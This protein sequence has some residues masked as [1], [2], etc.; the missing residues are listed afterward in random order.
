MGPW[1]HGQ[2]IGDGSSLGEI[3]FD[4]DTGLYFRRRILLPF[5][6]HFLK[7]SGPA[8]TTAPV[9]AFETGANEW[10]RLDAWPPK[11]VI[12]KP[13]YLNAG[14][15]VSFD[16][17]QAGSAAWEE[18]VSDP[19]KPVTYRPRPNHAIQDSAGSWSRWLVDDQRDVAS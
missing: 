11:S 5:L 8:L 18:Y 12:S 17:P 13:L 4:S 16:P 2:E 1:H 10:R 19:M 3:R 15:K 9:I 6:D 14:L 7:D